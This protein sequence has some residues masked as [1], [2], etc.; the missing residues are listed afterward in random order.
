MMTM[1]FLH[2]ATQLRSAATAELLSVLDETLQAMDGP[3]CHQDASRAA[4][5]ALTH[6]GR[7]RELDAA[8]AALEAM[9]LR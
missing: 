1:L 4:G 3:G 7:A 2:L 9:V 6:L 5:R 8:A